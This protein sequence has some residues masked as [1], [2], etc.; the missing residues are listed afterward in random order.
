MTTW[1]LAFFIAAFVALLATRAMIAVGISD[2][3]DE[4]RKLHKKVTPTSGGV[5]I[6]AGVFAGI[7]CAAASD[8]LP[9]DQKMLVALGVSLIGG[10]LGLLDDIYALGPKRKLAVMLFSVSAFVMFGARIE[11]LT[12]APNL[13]VNLGPIVGALGTIFWLLVLVNTVNFMDGA[14]GLSMGC[15]GIGLFWLCALIVLQNGVARN[16]E[17]FAILGWIGS[18]ACLGFLY[19]N[20]ANGKVFAGDSGA[21]FVGLF[22]GTLGVLAVVAGINPLSVA[23][24]FLPMLVDVILTVVLRLKRKENV[25]TAHAQH[26]YQLAIRHGATHLA[27]SARYWMYS[28]FCGIAAV[29]A[30]H[31]GGFAPLGIFL[32]FLMLMILAYAKLFM[33]IKAKQAAELSH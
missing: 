19:W 10:T 1:F 16:F 8:A 17:A 22:C 6:I 26:A 4:A 33:E 28:G 30:Q 23:T 3:P 9:L 21:L 7:G 31:K 25:L 32:I 13:V 27:T 20:A 29:V 11:S 15:S 14:N 2:N 5:G 24:C 18:A 12:L